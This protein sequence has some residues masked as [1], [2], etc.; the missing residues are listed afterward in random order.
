[1]ATPETPAESRATPAP[2]RPARRIAFRFAF[3][4]L[5]AYCFP[6]PEGLAGL[7]WN[8]VE[9]GWHALV[10]WVGARLLHIAAPISVAPTGSGDTT[11]SFVKLLC[12]AVLAVV[13]TI[14][15]SILDRRRMEYRSL[16]AWLRVYLRYVLAVIMV[17]YGLV[18][19][20]DLQFPLPRPERLTE[21]YGDSS[22]MGL[23]WSFMGTAP[24]YQ[25]F[26]GA[27]GG[28]GCSCIRAASSACR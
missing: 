20:F 21:A 2:W 24:A 10:P 18:K 13:A 28:G 17:G 1:M 5:V 11:Y 15:W 7:P 9:D 22:P 12:T 16:H 3:A 6:V 19:V 23:L 25:T 26:A 14:V 27:G 8:P 4:Y